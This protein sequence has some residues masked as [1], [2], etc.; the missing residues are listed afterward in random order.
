MSVVDEKSETLKKETM[1]LLGHLNT[2]KFS[3]QNSPEVS[4]SDKQQR[5]PQ[6][7]YNNSS[8][9]NLHTKSELPE[10]KL[11]NDP[12]TTSIIQSYIN[13]PTNIKGRND[14]LAQV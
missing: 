10:L 14:P 12:K 5:S 6:N 13:Y 1:H 3:N 9:R 11:K 8:K 4:Q 7:R 2:H